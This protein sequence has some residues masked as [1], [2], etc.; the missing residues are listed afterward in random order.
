MI[1]SSAVAHQ[2]KVTTIKSLQPAAGKCSDDI[3]EQL[4]RAARDDAG[5]RLVRE[6]RLN[7]VPSNAPITYQV[8]GRQ[9]VAIDVGNGGPQAMTFPPLVPETQNTD[10]AATIWVFKA[11]QE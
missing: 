4:Q 3:P 7:D 2:P 9:Y 6:I 11:R 8:N 1:Y 10:R 5:V